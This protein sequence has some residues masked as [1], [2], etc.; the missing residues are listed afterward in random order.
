[1]TAYYV[2]TLARYVVV[3]AESEAQARELGQVALYELY[4]D[5]RERLGREVPIKIHT[6]RPATTDEID[7]T[8]WHNEM[9]AREAR[10][11][12]QNRPSDSSSSAPASKYDSTD[13]KGF[14]P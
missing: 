13:Q 1:M 9:I 14:V 6:V 12:A 10:N 3:E 2:A 7:M 5:V 4:A 11:E 8:R